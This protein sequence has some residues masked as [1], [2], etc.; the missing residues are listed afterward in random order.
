MATIRR[1]FKSPNALEV[2]PLEKQP[3]PVIEY[4]YR[5]KSADFS[6]NPFHKSF[7][8]ILPVSLIRQKRA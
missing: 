4:H 2:N 1:I 5:P 7:N 8:R 3:L 6:A